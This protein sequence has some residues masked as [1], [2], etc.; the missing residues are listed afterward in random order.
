MR[1][2]GAPAMGP[3]PAP[4]LDRGWGG[5][6]AWTSRRGGSMSDRT[7]QTGE[8][9]LG[10]RITSAPPPHRLER[11][12]E[13]MRRE[14]LDATVAFGATNVAHLAGYARYYGGPAAVVVGADG[15]RTLVVMLDEVPV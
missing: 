2:L 4:V 15:H 6:A 1:A 7:G 12:R 5:T 13:W 3:R 8:A 9:G 10:G 14:S 11:L